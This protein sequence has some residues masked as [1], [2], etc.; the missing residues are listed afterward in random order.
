MPLTWSQDV[1]SS[2]VAS[3]GY[4]ADTQELYVTWAKN[5]RRSIYSNVPEDVATALANAPS[6]GSMINSDIK[7]NYEHRYG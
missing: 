2:N 4:D 1:L 3:V 6:V 5:G 7:P